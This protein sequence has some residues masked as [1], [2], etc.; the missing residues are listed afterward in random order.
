MTLTF[1]MCVPNACSCS[2]IA[3]YIGSYSYLYKPKQRG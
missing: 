3:S 2:G 1:C